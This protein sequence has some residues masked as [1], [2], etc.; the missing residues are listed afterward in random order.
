MFTRLPRDVL[1]LIAMFALPHRYK[2]R[3]GVPEKKLCK[4]S[5]CTNPNA[6]YYLLNHPDGKQQKY[7]PVKWW[8]PDTIC[9][10]SCD[11]AV[12]FI[13]SS[14][15]A[16]STLLYM[17]PNPHIV[18]L[19]RERP[20]DWTYACV[21]PNDDMV[22]LICNELKDNWHPEQWQ[23]W[24]KWNRLSENTN[25]RIVDLFLSHKDELGQFI[26]KL[27]SHP[28]ERMTS[29]L[30]SRYQE[31]MIWSDL[32]RNK[33]DT[34]CMYMISHPEC[35][36]WETA[37]SNPNDMMLDYL[38]DHTDLISING[39]SK[40]QNPRAFEYLFTYHREEINWKYVSE[41][42]NPALFT[43]LEK[44]TRQYVK[45]WTHRLLLQ[46]LKKAVS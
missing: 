37:S 22:D 28:S 25:E 21:N 38:F 3:D 32:A 15:Y 27:F 29:F 12:S 2:I 18:A 20:I 45:E 34:A 23:W 24:H 10:N 13:L 35:V 7:K 1:Y 30:F 17:N 11:E 4:N 46:P 14:S 5:L 40:N 16:Y 6:I 33:S 43:R 36:N 31:Y 9:R 44:E 42:A 19:L 26:Q 39:L 8:I 41:S